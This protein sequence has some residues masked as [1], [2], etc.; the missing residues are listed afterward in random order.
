MVCGC[1]SDSVEIDMRPFMKAY[2]AAEYDEWYQYWYGERLVKDR[3]NLI[4]IEVI[5]VNL[6]NGMSFLAY[7]SEYGHNF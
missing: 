1:R 6:S 3:S 2:R 7:S 4:F 5:A